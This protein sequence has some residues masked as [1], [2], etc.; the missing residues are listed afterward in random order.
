MVSQLH[1]FNQKILCEYTLKLQKRH[2]NQISSKLFLYGVK[3]FAHATF[4]IEHY[5]KSNSS[6][7]KN[8]ES[9]INDIPF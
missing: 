8:V 3:E 1:H 4:V 9:E 5:T 2:R 6:D 7:H